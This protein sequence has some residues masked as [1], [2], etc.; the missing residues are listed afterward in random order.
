[1]YHFEH[2]SHDTHRD[3]LFQIHAILFE[4]AHNP[5]RFTITKEI[6]DDI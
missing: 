3:Y 2:T 4:H 5:Y 1:M 6:Y